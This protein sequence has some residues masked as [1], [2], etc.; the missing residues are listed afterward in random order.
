MDWR[1]AARSTWQ[2][3]L[4]I[5]GCLVVL[6]LLVF[7]FGA[8]RVTYKELIAPIGP[9]ITETIGRHRLLRIKEFAV[10]F[11]PYAASVAGAIS[12]LYLVRRINRRDD[13]EYAAPPQDDDMED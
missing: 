5:S 9:V 11:A 3:T 8:I 4:N 7:W 2:S 1:R 6:F 12:I 10:E 13:P